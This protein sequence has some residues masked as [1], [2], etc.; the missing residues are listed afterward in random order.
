MPIKHIAGIRN[1]DYASNLESVSN[2][3]AKSNIN[4]SQKDPMKIGQLQQICIYITDRAGNLVSFLDGPVSV[5]L[6]FKKF[7]YVL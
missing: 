5:T 7:P 1:H 2:L 6:H 4:M 3:V